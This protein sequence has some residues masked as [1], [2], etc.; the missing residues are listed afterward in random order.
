MLDNVLNEVSKSEFKAR[1]KKLKATVEKVPA[2]GNCQFGALA[3]QLSLIPD[4]PKDTAKVIRKR[5]C[6]Y[7]KTNA[8]KVILLI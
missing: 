5:I 8:G 6:D 7:L 1:I 2:D 4:A 3:H